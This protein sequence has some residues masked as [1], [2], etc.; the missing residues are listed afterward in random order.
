MDNTVNY[1]PS[2][3]N[4]GY[5]LTSAATFGLKLLGCIAILVIGYFVATFLAKALDKILERV[6]FDRAIERGGIKQAM[7]R[8]G[9]DASTLV[10]KVVFYALML[11]VLSF[12]LSVF[13]PNPISN[14]LSQFI[15]YFP[16]ILVAIGIVVLAC[17]IGS[18]VRDIVNGAM[19]GLSY[20]RTIATVASV[21]IIML[22]VFMALDQLNIAPAIVNG[23]WYAMLAIIVGVS[24]VAI[25]GG[26]IKPM[27]E[28]WR[29][30]MDRVDQEV[31]RIAQS[32]SATTVTPSMGQPVTPGMY[33]DQPGTVYP[34]TP[35]GSGYVS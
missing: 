25:G 27:E 34:N 18:A 24:V 23:L 12:A 6:G 21:G 13:G 8:S 5:I 30:A 33:P 32:A 31:P 1:N 11:F 4:V 16:N 35:G 2:T 10:S 19:G 29:T 22:G 17:A 9:W 14:A 20:G 3:W 7:S 28:R 26:G 15:A